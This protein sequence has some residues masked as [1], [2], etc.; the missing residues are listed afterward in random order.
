MNIAMLLE[1]SADGMGDRI[2]LGPLE[3]G[4]SYADLYARARRAGNWLADQH[5]AQV[6]MIDVNSSAVP[7]LLFG[8]ALAGKPF[9]PLNYRLA[10]DRLRDIVS[11]TTPSIAIVDAQM[12]PRVQGMPDVQVELRQERVQEFDSGDIGSTDASALDASGLAALLFTSGTTGEPKAAVL[13]HQNLF[14]YIIETV[15]FMSADERECALVSVPAYHIA[16]IS[17]VLSSVFAGRR[18][19]YLEQFDPVAWVELARAE[20]VTHAMVV[21]TMLGRILDVLEDRG[22]TL[23]A[24][25]HLSYGGGR[26]PTPIVERALA[27]LENV[28]FVN[29]YGLTETSSTVSVLSPQDHRMAFNHPEPA[30]RARL[31]SVGRPLPSLE[32]EIRDILGEAVNVGVVGEIWVRGGQVSGEYLGS[33]SG[34][35]N[36]WFPTRDGGRLDK[37][38]YLY[39]EGRMDDVIVRGGENLSPAEIEEVL[40]SHPAVADVAVLGIPDLEWGEAVK[41]VVVSVDGQQVTGAELQE[42]VRARLRSSRVPAVVAFRPALPYTETGKLLRRELRT[43]AT[44]E[45]NLR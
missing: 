28:N 1:M 27:M 14:S 7:V 32:L 38:G 39:L 36:G 13:R 26:M 29:A 15:E 10:D 23:P 2:G 20:S 16:G 33:G 34:L 37:D 40:R 25:K 43:E 4:L 11:R 31:G 8:C 41:A 6:V 30:I 19:V 42:W 12:A 17:A 35:Q 5:G 24:L 45:A 44:G 22:I 9:V 18:L 21:P 3:G